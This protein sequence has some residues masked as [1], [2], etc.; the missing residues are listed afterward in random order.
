MAPSIQLPSIMAAA[1]PTNDDV[2]MVPG[3]FNFPRYSTGAIA[4]FVNSESDEFINKTA[5]QSTA[6]DKQDLI[7]LIGQS[8]EF[9]DA[10]RQWLQQVLVEIRRVMDATG[11][12]TDA[13]GASTAATLPSAAAAAAAVPPSVAATAALA[14]VAA[15]AA[16]AALPDC[17]RLDSNG[18]LAEYEAPS[19]LWGSLHLER[20]YH[21]GANSRSGQLYC[22][23][24]A[25]TVGCI[26][27]LGR[28]IEHGQDVNAGSAN[29]SWTALDF[30]NW[31]SRDAAA[32]FLRSRG[33]KTRE[34]N[35]EY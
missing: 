15:P 22:F 19:P 30:A 29:N 24:A 26:G 16:V 23:F 7:D 31:A 18:Q 17:N 32:Q 9:G 14:A 21:T 2:V 35:N 13:M 27:C 25:A 1:S 8:L 33:G 34:E 3:D 28:A 10:R 6:S 4:L 11:A 5:E 20:K 12:D